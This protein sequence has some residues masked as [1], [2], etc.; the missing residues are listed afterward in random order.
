MDIT[1]EIEKRL[2]SRGREFTLRASFS[3]SDE[4]VVLFGPSGSGKTL[5]LRALSGLMRPDA[6]RIEVDGRVLFDA[7]KRIHVP[8]RR[9]GIGY[10][11]QD[12]ALFP[13]LNVADN[14]AF[15][16]NRTWR[17]TLPADERHRVA[18]LLEVFGLGRLAASAPAEL[19]GGQRQRVALARALA[20]RPKLLLLDEPFAA[21][22]QPMRAKMRDNLK[23]VQQHFHVPAVL[24]SHDPDDVEALADTLVVFEE[25]R[26]SRVWP[27]RSICQR[28]KVAR[29]VRSTFGSTL[30][31]GLGEGVAP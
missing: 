26:V 24:I 23:A 7:R 9:R 4:F 5:T 2:S 25:G 28:R 6:G 13:H 3:A 10:L 15:G 19:S 14:V 21:L 16:L 29:F 17:G 30:N 12:Y 31:Q 27:F 1:V 18:E 20:C 11:F 22:D 8:A